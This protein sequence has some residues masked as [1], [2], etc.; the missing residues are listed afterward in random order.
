MQTLMRMARKPVLGGSKALDRAGGAVV[1]EGRE[2]GGFNITFGPNDHEG[3]RFTDLS[4]IGPG[5]RF[6]H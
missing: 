6:I 1:D 2:L 4:I 3:S 5:N